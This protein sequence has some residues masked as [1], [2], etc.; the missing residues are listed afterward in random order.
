MDKL[1]KS[2]EDV[3]AALNAEPVVQEFEKAKALV[4]SDKYVQQMEAKLKVLQQKMTQNVMDKTLH[5]TYKADYETLKKEYDEHP[6][7]VNYNALL[8]D[9]NDLLLMLKNIIE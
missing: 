4:T 3:I 1:T 9:V 5:E 7:V 6:Y 2:I 8:N